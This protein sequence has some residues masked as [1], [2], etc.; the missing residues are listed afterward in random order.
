MIS[1][2][3]FTSRMNEEQK[4]EDSIQSQMDELNVNTEDQA[5]DP[6]IIQML[7][8][9]IQNWEKLSDVEKK[10][11]LQLTIDS[12]LIERQEGKRKKDRIKIVEIIF[13]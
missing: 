11:L 9:Q 12:I 4:K 6:G 3:E 1:D 7:S 2:D 8:D 13:Q 5:V 10:Q